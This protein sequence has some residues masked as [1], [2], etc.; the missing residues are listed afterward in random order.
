[1]IRT[2][3]IA[4]MG[5]F[6]LSVA[7]VVG[8]KAQDGTASGIIEGKDTVTAK[9]ITPEAARGALFQE[10]NPKLDAAPERRAGYAGAMA[11]SPNGKLS[12]EM[13]KAM[14]EVQEQDGKS[15]PEK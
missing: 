4:V 15:A 6:A 7:I 1:M 12:D 2:T 10:L 13:L 8:I 9:S 3:W 11:A 5:V 14:L